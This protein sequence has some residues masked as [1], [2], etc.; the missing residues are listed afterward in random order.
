MTNK[1]L[2]EKVDHRIKVN[3][4]A[5]MTLLGLFGI[6]L[7]LVCGGI[8]VFLILFQ[9]EKE[10]LAMMFMI[11]KVETQGGELV[12]TV[13][14]A[15][16]CLEAARKKAQKLHEDEEGGYTVLRVYGFPMDLDDLEDMEEDEEP[17][18]Q[19][20]PIENQDPRLN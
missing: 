13:V 18:P 17:E 10:E 7:G 6:A 11:A 5:A 16:D 19:W 20:S 15:E 2:D 4:E 14:G 3:F 12:L 1:D 8:V 9:S